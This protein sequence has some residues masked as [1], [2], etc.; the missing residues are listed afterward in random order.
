[1][2]LLAGGFLLIRRRRPDDVD[3]ELA[4]VPLVLHGLSK[5]YSGGVVA[6]DDLSFDVRKGQVVGLL[7]PN[8]AGKTTA[9]RMVMGLV[10]PSAGTIRLFG[11]LVR[12]GSPVLSRI[13]SF[14]E[15]PGFLPHLSGIANLRLYWA[16][17]GRPTEHARFDDALRIAG[18]GNAV[19]RRV[20]T[21]SQGMRQRL[22]IA[23][24]MLG[25]PDLLILDEPT[26]GLD[27]PQ[28]RD[29]RDVLRGYAAGG[30]TV[31]VSSHLLTEV[32]QTCTHV[33]VMHQGRLVASGDVSEIVGSG[34]ETSFRVDDADRAVDVLRAL[35]GLA[36]PSEV[37]ASDGQVY[38]KLNGVPRSAAVDALVR[39]GIAVDQV[40]PR[41]RLE[42]AFLQLVGGGAA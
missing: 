30:R 42:D 16:A 5:S 11:H 25:L 33:V 29:M 9:L 40:G 23:Q 36:E 28:I 1:L 41:G 20:G 2:C 3:P 38:A 17:T 37:A 34:G 13:G 35:P 27:P 8:G 14:V 7:G 22:A 39:A 21:Y 6:V 18:L 10:H 19:R 32:E 26:N 15:G 31:L 4:D 24:S 12:P